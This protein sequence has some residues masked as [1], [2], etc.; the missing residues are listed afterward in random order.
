MEIHG[1]IRFE[2]T[3]LREIKKSYSRL[4]LTLVEVIK[5]EHI[6]QESNKE[7]NFRLASSHVLG[8]CNEA[9]F[10]FWV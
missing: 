3:K 4:K 6:N 5:K 1:K 8:T 7:Y 10:L 9:L 2:M